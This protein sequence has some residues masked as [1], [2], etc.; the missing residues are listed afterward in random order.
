MWEEY[1]RNAHE[2]T[3]FLLKRPK[4]MTRGRG[5][6]SRFEKKEGGFSAVQ[7]HSTR[8]IPDVAI[9]QESAGWGRIGFSDWS[10]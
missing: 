3:V 7:N 8:W 2:Q 1:F 9:V 4:N 5:G 6:F 10:E